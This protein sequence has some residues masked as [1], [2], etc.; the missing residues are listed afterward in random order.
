M[1]RNEIY[2]PALKTPVQ[3]SARLAS[4]LGKRTLHSLTS[5]MQE[6]RSWRNTSVFSFEDNSIASL[7]YLPAT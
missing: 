1:L 2:I 3:V 5:S 6:A 4:L 7:P